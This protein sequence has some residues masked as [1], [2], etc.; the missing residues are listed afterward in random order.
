MY[1]ALGT[2]PGGAPSLC[3]ELLAANLLGQGTAGAAIA[4]EDLRE[5][6]F[7]CRAF[8]LATLDAAQFFEQLTTFSEAAFYWTERLASIDAQPALTP[9]AEE[10]PVMLGASNMLRV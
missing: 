1:S 10:V 4:L 6:L 7:L 9:A 3:R 2:L 8:E 5:E